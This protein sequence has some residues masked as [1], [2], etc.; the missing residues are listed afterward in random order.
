MR[1]P[2]L[3][4]TQKKVA[5]GGGAAVGVLALTWLALRGSKSSASDTPNTGSV[6]LTATKTMAVRASPPPADPTDR[7]VKRNTRVLAWPSSSNKNGMAYIKFTD[8]AH[9]RGG[10]VSDNAVLR[11]SEQTPWSMPAPIQ[12]GFSGVGA[13]QVQ[14]PS[15]QQQEVNAQGSSVNATV[16]SDSLMFV[17]PED[18]AKLETLQKEY[19]ALIGLMGSGKGLVIPNED[20]FR[21]VYTHGTGRVLGLIPGIFFKDGKF[22]KDNLTNHSWCQTWAAQVVGFGSDYLWPFYNQSVY[23]Y[24]PNV[25]PDPNLD[26]YPNSPI[27]PVKDN[28]AYEAALSAAVEADIQ[29]ALQRSSF[30]IILDQIEQIMGTPAF[31][32][33][34][35]KDAPR[36]VFILEVA[37]DVLDGLARFG[38][39]FA[40]DNDTTKNLDSK[41]K[42]AILDTVNGNINGKQISGNQL[43]SIQASVG[44]Y[45]VGG[46]IDMFES[47]NTDKDKGVVNPC[48]RELD[49][50]LVIS[51]LIAV[52]SAFLAVV[53][54]GSAGLLGP[55]FQ[56]VYWS[57]YTAPSAIKGLADLSK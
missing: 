26:R 25:T 52:V 7:I 31:G 36:D 15:T 48:I 56:A 38:H 46:V 53:S 55:V 37:P 51:M 41:S 21:K 33:I 28:A 49:A 42:Q 44:T 29:A 34:F 30:G 3:S 11:D 43:K 4:K 13:L 18:K 10:W 17:H 24:G 19:F 5:I 6:T 40:S 2:H 27:D 16:I 20:T 9:V 45:M 8:G 54:L 12:K 32:I 22:T 57:L 23:R 1:L 14:V 39:D 47:H 35:G 50:G